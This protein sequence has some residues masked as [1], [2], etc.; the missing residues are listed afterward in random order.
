MGKYLKSTDFI[1]FATG[2]RIA[3]ITLNRPDKRNALNPQMITELHNA[4]IEADALVEV[5][6]IVLAGQ[7]KISAPATTSPVRTQAANPTMQRMPPGSKTRS[8]A[9]SG[10]R[11][12][13]TAGKSSS[14]SVSC[15]YCSRSI[16][17]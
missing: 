8:T 13:M 5:N 12:T 9:H 7:A 1:G 17:P 14:S 4:L 3:R 10:V 15:P 16:S 2:D 6:V 11:S